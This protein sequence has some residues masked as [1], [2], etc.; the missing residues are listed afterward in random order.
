MR[1][2]QWRRLPAR[3][4]VTTRAHLDGRCHRGRRH[5]RGPHPR[6][7]AGPL[8]RVP[9]H[10][11]R[12]RQAAGRARRRADAERRADGAVD[13]QPRGRG[14]G[15]PLPRGRRGR[16]PARAARLPRRHAAHDRPRL[17]PARRRPAG[18]CS[19]GPSAPRHDGQP[20]PRVGILFYRAQFAAEN[21]AYVH[22]LADAVDAAGRHR[23][24]PSTCARC[25]TPSA[26]LLEHLA[27][28]TRSSPR[29]SRPA[30]PSPRSAG[31]RRRRGLGRA[32]P[33]PRSTCPIL[34]ALCL[35]WSRE[36]W[37]ASDDGISPL[38]AATQVAV[39][40]F[41]GRIITVPFSFKEIDDDGLPRLRAP[42]PSG[43]P[44]SPGSPSTT[45]GCGTSRRP[46]GD[47]AR[48][49]GLPDQALA[50]RQRGRSRHAG[51]TIRLLRACATRVRLRCP[52]DPARC[53]ST[54]TPTRRGTRS[55]TR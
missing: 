28:T 12:R 47:R 13:R 16:Q 8:R 27:A 55:S 1:S 34:Q 35:T 19:T 22:A 33:W 2:G 18:A 52:G 45:P 26:E 37:E 6:R 30:A 15:P 11:R 7:P 39:P 42:T 46:S 3:Q 44:A 43:A 5:R 31:R 53:P 24:C 20:A 51:P 25:A 36:R 14:R 10:P 21:T 40:E 49:V 41:D 50:H 54:A 4:P 23:R 17:R 29:C 9:P 32:A 48:P 38:D